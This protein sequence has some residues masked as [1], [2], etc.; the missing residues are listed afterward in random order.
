VQYSLIDRRPE[1]EMAGLCAEHDVQLLAYGSVCGG[2][3]SERYLGA[4]EPNRFDL[5]TASLQK[6]R[7]MVDAWGGWALF[8]SLLR[9]INAVASRQG[10]SMANVAVRYVLDRPAVGGVIVGVR[11]GLS[12]HLEDNARVF[13]LELSQADLAEI[14]TVLAQGRDLF[15]LI[16]D[17]GDEYRQ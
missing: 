9:A 10:A 1:V 14:D 4:R 7:Q 3:L 16:G 6:Y 11:L 17:C 13:A 2:L 5:D 8:Q 15:R 12:D